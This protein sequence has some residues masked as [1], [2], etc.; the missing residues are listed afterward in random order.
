[1]AD[2]TLVVPVF[3]ESHRWRDAYWSDLLSLDWIHWICVDDGST[4]LTHEILLRL[5][6]PTNY[7]ILRLASNQGKGEAVRAGILHFFELLSS[8]KG[9][10]F[11]E[12]KEPC[13]LIGFIDADGSITSSDI[14]RMYQIAKKK[15]SINSEIPSYHIDAPTNAIWSSRV[16]LNGR[17][18]ERKNS[19]HYIGRVINKLLSP[20]FHSIPYDP[21]CGF[22]I[23]EASDDFKKSISTP[24]KTRWFFDL[25]IILKWQ[26]EIHSDFQIWEEPLESWKEISGS[27]LSPLNIFSIFAEILK[28]IFESRTILRESKRYGIGP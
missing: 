10:S 13:T 22:K 11:L 23:F 15:I 19:R 3:N 18:I 14:T 4:D 17:L 7:E 16:A 8:D 6:A 24:F 1:M 9:K 28:I 5:P 12:S 21:Q 25:E 27:H 2:L 26:K 20:H